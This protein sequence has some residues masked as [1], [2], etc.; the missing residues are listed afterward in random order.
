MKTIKSTKTKDQLL[1]EIEQLK[2]QLAQARQEAADYHTLFQQAKAERPGSVDTNEDSELKYSDVYNS[3]SDG[4][5]LHKIVKDESGKAEDYIITDVNQAFEKITGLSKEKI[6]GK[7][8]RTAYSTDQA[9]YLEIYSRVVETGESNTFETFFPPMEKHFQITAFSL[10]NGRFATVFQDIT[11]RISNED[12]FKNIM[13]RFHLILSSMPT[14]ILLLSRE[15]KVEFAN[16]AFCEMFEL[17][18]TPQEL[19][20]LTNEEVLA[21]INNRYLNPDK[22]LNKIKFLVESG[23]PKFGED[24]AMRS[25]RTLLRDFI[26]IMIGN[27]YLGRLWSHIDFSERTK[28]SDTQNFLLRNSFDASEGDFFMNLA[29][30]LSEILGMEYVCIDR[31]EEDSLN[32]TTLA[33][34]NSGRFDPNISYTLKDTPCGD[35]VGKTVCCFPENV[36][37]LFPLDNALV[38]L[39]AES[40][41][42]TTLWSHNDR[43]IGLIAVIG[44]K[45][46]TNIRF[47]EV[48]I[49][50]AALRASAELERKLSDEALRISESKFS[51]LFNAAP[52]AMSLATTPDGILF[53]VNQAWLDMVNIKDKKDVLGKTTVA[54]GLI[55]DPEARENILKEFKV[56]GNVKNTELRANT[57]DGRSITLLINVDVVDIFGTK[58]LL[59]TNN[60]IT[61]RVQ[62]VNQLRE[63]EEKFL[64]IFNL[65]PLP[66][67][68]TTI[69]EGIF[70]DINESFIRDSGFSREE[71]IGKSSVEMNLFAVK[72]GR[73]TLLSEIRYRGHITGIDCDFRSKDGSIHN[74]LLS[75]SYIV[76][77]GEGYILST[78]QNI[79]DILK[80]REALKENEQRLWSVLDA[81]LEAIYMYDRQGIICMSNSTGI[82]RLDRKVESD[83]VGH[84]IS[85]FMNREIAGFRLEK[86]EEVFQ[87]GIPLEFTDERECRIYHHNYFPVFNGSQVVHVVSYSSDITDRQK[88]EAKLIESEDRFRTIAESLTVMIS[89]FRIC[90]STLTFTNEPFEKKFGLSQ[91]GMTLKSLTENFTSPDDYTSIRTIL[92]DGGHINN[93]EVQ[94][95]R[96]DGSVFWIMLSLRK[97]NFLNEPSYLSVS[98]D[99]TESKK[100]QLELIRLNRILNA[101]NKSSQAMMHTINELSCIN[102]VCRIIIEDCGHSMVWVGYAQNDEA[103]SVIPVANYGFDEG[104]IEQ[105]NISWGDNE[106]GRGPTGIAIRTGKPS[107]CRNMLTDPDFA[108]WRDA[109]LERG[110]ASSLVLPLISDGKPFGAISIYSMEPDPF[111]EAEINLLT[112]LADDLAYGIKFMRLTESER[113]AAKAIRENEA[114]LKDLIVTKDK[115]FNIVAHDLKNPFTSLLGSSELLYENINGMDSENVRELALILNDSAKS[116][117]A[118]LQ[119]LLD[120]SRSQTGLIQFNPENIN[121]RKIIEENID[122][123]QLQVTNKDINLTTDLTTDLLICGDKNMINTIL[124]NLLS[125]AV[126]Y[127]YKGGSIRVSALNARDEIIVSVRDSG[128]GIQKEYS[129]SLFRLENGLSL[130]GTEKEQ[131]TGL[132][133]KLCQEFTDLMGGKIWVKS[134]PEKGSI[135]YFTI[136][137]IRPKK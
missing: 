43:P 28:I 73:S 64:S 78:V 116:G 87:R 97:I 70:L 137:V 33:I 11:E 120:W 121:L 53:D 133:L 119:N 135:F 109:A 75:S 1:S 41:I 105:L 59:S 27:D 102:D 96:T 108:P 111:Y 48:I 88:A 25:G 47:A 57:A 10:G 42:G 79:T 35:V 54:A 77:N 99:I 15:N 4:F 104:Y 67:S 2:Q 65:S 14:G 92:K 34:Y 110:Y 7:K 66:M 101:H 72:N 49:K 112:K 24:V 52:V 58:F 74:C 38:E 136:P 118:I 132:G 71:I 115:F 31:L 81:T 126:K 85:E 89:I 63:S 76:I 36:R 117:Y 60:D 56:K 55:P 86:I 82:E 46:I 30:F 84:H 90:D 5:A 93:R 124:R 12:K 61:E 129:D 62:T 17:R 130:P 13:D 8:A 94:I 114:K 123:L 23:I 18:E 6:I 127:T 39:N 19:L 113:A 131:G 20:K 107:M 32:A 29:S 106:R 9:P 100:A 37:N 21:K 44:S 80:T 68:L 134:E 103:K 128:I 95:K 3:M 69:D 83:I 91:N 22:E 122:N 125:N 40:Y 98:I 45:P 16:R 50:L 51:T 26:P